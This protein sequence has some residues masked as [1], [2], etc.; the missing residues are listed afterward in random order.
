[1]AKTQHRS[2]RRFVCLSV[3][4]EREHRR[5]YAKSHRVTKNL[6]V[7][8]L[9]IKR[10][11]SFPITVPFNGINATIKD[12]YND[13][14]LASYIVKEDYS[15]FSINILLTRKEMPDTYLLSYLCNCI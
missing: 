13:L 8:R 12:R 3:N 14:A 5:T 9:I 11:I 2:L 6:E 10:Y 7:T 1:M 4:V 15:D